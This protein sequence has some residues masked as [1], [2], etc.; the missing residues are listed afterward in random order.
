[1][2]DIFYDEDAILLIGGYGSKAANIDSYFLLY[3]EELT[4]QALRVLPLYRS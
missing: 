3:F 1:M 4:L 2:V